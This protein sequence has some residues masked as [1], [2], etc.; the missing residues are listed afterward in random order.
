MNSS[1][2]L[3]LEMDQTTR[4]NFAFRIAVFSNFNSAALLLNRTCHQLE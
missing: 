3:H 4:S 2:N 1:L